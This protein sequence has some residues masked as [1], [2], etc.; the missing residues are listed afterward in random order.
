MLTH[1]YVAGETM[2][3]GKRGSWSGVTQRMAYLFMSLFICLFIGG[4][5]QPACQGQKIT[6]ERESSSVM[7]VP[8]T[9]LKSQA[10]RQALLPT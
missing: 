5:L 4:M 8:R 9:K 6:W 3:L 10:W 1:L 7:Y 2:V